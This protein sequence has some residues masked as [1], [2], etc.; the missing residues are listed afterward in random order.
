MGFSLFPRR[1]AAQAHQAHKRTELLLTATGD[2]N[3]S[4]VAV[5]NGFPMEA[6]RQPTGIMCQWPVCA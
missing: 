1:L 4:L 5:P 2:M 6:P 3:Q